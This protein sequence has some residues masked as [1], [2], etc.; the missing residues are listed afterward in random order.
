MAEKPCLH[1]A[2]Q[3]NYWAYKK[4]SQ[5][6]GKNMAT[7][8]IGASRT[9]CAQMVWHLTSDAE[10]KLLTDFLGG[11]KR[12]RPQ[13]EKYGVVERAPTRLRQTRVASQAYQVATVATMTISAILA[14]MAVGG[15]PLV[16]GADNAWCRYLFYNSVDAI[17]G[18][19]SRGLGFFCPL[20]QGLSL[21]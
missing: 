7:C 10:W 17:M 8:M 18:S 12:G 15:V 1:A 9:R 3:A 13:D 2:P 11:D 6:R 16:Y 14:R 4:Q 20:P 21:F 5:E 19:G